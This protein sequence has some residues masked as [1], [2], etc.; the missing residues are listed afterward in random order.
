MRR[1]GYYRWA[2]QGG[3]WG[4]AVTTKLGFKAPPGL[5]GIHLNMVMFQPTDEERAAATP[6]EQEILDRSRRYMEQFS[7]YYQLQNTRPQSIAFSLADSPV[8]LAAWIYAL[9]Q[10]VLDSGSNPE[11][12]FPLDEMLDDIM[13]YWLPN[14][15]P[16]SARLYWEAMREMMNGGL[17]SMPMPAGISNFPGEQGGIS[18][19]WAEKR[20]A[21]IVHFN[22]PDHGGHFAAPGAAGTFHPR[23]AGDLPKP[24]GID[25]QPGAGRSGSSRSPV[26][27]PVPHP[28]PLTPCT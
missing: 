18:C 26:N 12:V 5:V 7:G 3:D 4:A 10:D 1:L 9:F 25:T 22:H 20:F 2:A 11:S 15:G 28:T 16:S 24:A 6:A 13:L 8:G 23:G 17:P 27:R 14:A 19:R 21:K